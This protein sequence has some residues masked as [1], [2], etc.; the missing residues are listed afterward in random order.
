ME[1]QQ[2]D[3]GGTGKFKSGNRI[4]ETRSTNGRERIFAEPYMMKDSAIE[5]FQWMD[6][7]PLYKKEVKWS[8]SM[9]R[10]VDTDVPVRRPYTIISF[11]LFIGVHSGF[12]NKFKRDC[13]DKL[14]NDKTLTKEETERFT[15]FLSVIQII[16]ESIYSQKFEGASAGFFNANIISRDLGL[17]DKQHL[18][19]PPDETINVT[20]NL[21]K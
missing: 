7:N 1:D 19:T 15:D 8:E 10:W 3:I 18:S 11:C 5:Y 6:E 4:W 14:D 16:E 9:G 12:L 2:Q 17:A 20:L 21:G 13:K